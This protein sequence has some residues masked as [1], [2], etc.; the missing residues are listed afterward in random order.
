MGTGSTRERIS[1]NLAAIRIAKTIDAE[2]RLATPDEQQVLVRYVGWG[3]LSRIFEPWKYDEGKKD[4]D[5][6]VD[7]NKTLVDLLTTDEFSRARNSTQNAHYTSPVVIRAI[8][9]AVV[10]LGVTSGSVLEPSAGIG[11]FAGL[12]PSQL[13]KMSWAMVEKDPV[14][15]LI[16]KALYPGAFIQP[17]GFEAAALPAD[18]FTLAISNVPFGS[19]PITDPSFAGPSFMLQRIHNYFFGK[20]LDA[21]APGGLIA[22]ITTHGTLDSRGN[23]RVREYLASRADLVGAMRLPSTAFKANAGTDV[24]TDILFLRRRRAGESAHHA[25]PWLHTT[26]V[27]LPNKEGTPVEQYVN[28]YMLAHPEMVLGT[29]TSTGKMRAADAYN[30][31]PSGDLAE[32]LAAA[33][34]TLPAHVVDTSPPATTLAA[35]QQTQPPAGTRPFEYLLHEGRLAQIID[36]QVTPL[37]LRTK[38]DVARITKLL[39]VRAA[40]R[41]LYDLLMTPDSA[42]A[43][44]ARA[45]K[46]LGKAY[47]AFVKAHGFIAS[48]KNYRAFD[49]DPDMPLLL[50]LEDY[51]DERGVATKTAIFTQRT[52]QAERLARRANSPEHA[53]QLTLGE[54]GQIDLDRIGDLLDKSAADAARALQSAGL[55]LDTPSGWDLPA[56]YLAGNIRVR[57]REAEAAAELD[58]RYDGAVEALKAVM[59]ETIPSHKINVRLGASW[60]PVPTV[61]EFLKHATS[62]SLDSWT[63]TYSPFDGKWSIDGPPTAYA[64]SFTTPDVD[65]KTMLL[66]ALNDKRLTI[67]NK[68]STPDGGER[69]VVNKANTALARAK[70]DEIH[71][72]FGEWLFNSDP[73][74]RAWAVTAY[75]ERFNAYVQPTINGSYLTFPGMSAY[76]RERMRPHQRDAVGRVLSMG[77]LLFAHVVGAGKTLAMVAAGME[78][79]RLGLAR[80]PLYVVPNHL[81]AQW[82]SEFLQYYPNARLLVAK[83]EDLKKEN[84]KRF[85]A[86]IASGDWDAVVMPFSSF[87]LVSISPDAE[88]QYQRETLD[89][90]ETAIVQAWST[91]AQQPSRR[92]GKQKTPPSVKNLEKMRDRIQSKLD[93]LAQRPKDEMLWFEQLGVDALLVDEA[94]AFKNLYFQTRQQ[95]AGIP[96]DNDADRATDMYLKVRHINRLTNYRNVVLATG[97][98]VSN[99]MAEIFVLQKMLQEQTLDR[100]GVNQF[101]AWLAQFGTITVKPEQDPSGTGLSARARLSDFRN[102]PDLAAMVRQVVDVKMI[103]DLPELKAARPKLRGDKVE[104]PVVPITAR[105]L[106]YLAD[107][108]HRADN[109]DPRDKVTDNMGKLSMDGRLS[110]LDMR[111]I[112]RRIS[113][114]PGSKINRVVQDVYDIWAEWNDRKGVQLL[115]LDSGVPGTEENAAR[116][117]DVKDP[118]TGE[119]VGKRPPTEAEANRGLDLYKDM[120]TKL[121]DRGVPA[122]QIVFITDL[123]QVAEKKRDA[124]RKALFRRVRNGDIRILIGSRARM[125]TGMNVQDR[126]VALHNIDPAWKPSDIEQAN[127]RILRQGNLFLKEDPKFRVRILNHVT[128]GVG[129]AFGY[130]AYMWGLNEKKAE[131]IAKFW[132]GNLSERDLSLD[133]EQTVLTASEMKAIATGNPLIMEEG[134]L[135]ADVDRLDL[136]RQG[137]QESQREAAWSIEAERTAL[138]NLQDDERRYQ[139]MQAAITPRA[140]SAPLTAEVDGHTLEGHKVIGEAIL[141]AARAATTES[142]S[143]P[144]VWERWKRPQILGRFRGL[145]MRVEG[146]STTEPYIVLRHPKDEPPRYGEA[147]DSPYKRITVKLLVTDPEGPG[148]LSWREPTSL[149]RVIENQVDAIVEHKGSPAITM[150]EQRIAQFERTMSAPFAQQREYQQAVAKLEEVRKALGIDMKGEEIDAGDGGDEEPDGTEQAMEIEPSQQEP[151]SRRVKRTGLSPQDVEFERDEDVQQA[152]IEG[153]TATLPSLRGAFD[154]VSQAKSGVMALWA[155][156]TLPAGARAATVLRPEM[157]QLRHKTIVAAKA[158]RQLE[159]AFDRLTE[160]EWTAFAV[161]VDEGHVATLPAWQ[162]E[163][164]RLMKTINDQKLKTINSLGGRVPYTLNYYAREWVRPNAARKFIAGQLFR[165]RPLQGPAKFKK[166]RARHEDTGETFTFKELYDAG[167]R[168]VEGNPIRAHLRKWLEKDKWIMAKRTL[169]EL[170]RQGLAEYVPTGKSLKRSGWIPYDDGFGTVWGPPVAGISEAYDAGLMEAIHTFAQDQGIT[171]VRKMEMGK[172]NLQ[173][174][175]TWGY[176]VKGKDAIHSRFG[177]PEGVLMHEIGHVL[178]NKYGLGKA[179]GLVMN[180]ERAEEIN[181]SETP[182]KVV[183]ELRN[184]ADL[185]TDKTSSAGFRQ[186]VRKR[187]EVIANLVHAFLYVPDKAKEVAPSAYWAL[188]NMAKDTPS[189]AGLLEI[190]KA[191]SLRFASNT[192]AVDLGGP[193]LKGRYYGPRDAVRILNNHLSPGLRGNQA[194]DLYRRVGNVLNQVQLGLSGF[195][196]VGTSLNSVISKQAIAI[197]LASRG[198]ILE[199]AKRQLEV[200]IAPL[201]DVIRAHTIV[202]GAY[203]Q[204][205]NWRSLTTDMDKIIGAGGGVNWDTFWHN[206][207]PERFM[208]AMRATVAEAKAGHAVKASAHAGQTLLRLLPAIIE[209]QAKPIMQW[210]VPRLKVA[211]FMDLARME[212]ADLGPIPEPHETARVLG[213]AWD[214]VDNRFGELIYDNLFWNRIFKDVSMSLVRSMGWNLGTVREVLGAVPGQ[215]LHTWRQVAGGAGGGEPPTRLRNTGVTEGPDGEKVPVYERGPEPAITHKFAYFLSLLFWAA[216]FGALYQKLM[217]SLNPGEQEDGSTDTQTLLLDLYFP[218]TGG[219]TSDGR[220]ERASLPTYM[221]DVYAFW[222]HPITTMQHKVH[223]ILGLAGEV[224]WWNEDYFGNEIRDRSGPVEEQIRDVFDHLAKAYRPISVSSYFE[225]QKNRSGGAIAGVQSFLGINVAPASVTRTAMEEYIHDTRPPL[226]RTKSEAAKADLRREIRDLVSKGDLDEARRVAAEAGLST[227]Q[228]KSLVHTTRQGYVQRAFMGLGLRQALHAYEIGTPQER[229]QVIGILRAKSVRDL[230]GLQVDERARLR[231]AYVDALKLDRS[232]PAAASPP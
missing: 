199:A 34:K 135:A 35:F 218:R 64:S 185:R 3:G 204:D 201:V 143:S 112:D 231:D 32:Q 18:H 129:Q 6:W 189:L 11:H 165:R 10:R 228:L 69:T 128:S 20:A 173:G 172:P 31:E 57:L 216:I 125:G 29:P 210:W 63:V 157:A 38:D 141:D 198:H 166:Q 78:M 89:A 138:T 30:V 196:F 160:D 163:V 195:H 110:A 79:R 124:A 153:E 108:K 118:E 170:K 167:F 180:G 27:D 102:L 162:Q 116:L 119:K 142:V 174:H 46:A 200:P 148:G 49:E 215:A 171:M 7:A 45:Q 33:I 207:A 151:G 193:V 191:R 155:P 104:V 50:S 106:A 169:L 28:E 86:R 21:V 227:T 115:F 107:M 213:K 209:Q 156:D 190:Q 134:K 83:P 82:P 139:T 25:G 42:D 96:T 114:D 75:N 137:W 9:D 105:Q 85:T 203:A 87:V 224:L 61:T 62:S 97:T 188:Y 71:K 53:L 2:Q 43:D 161:A 154:E 149:T 74:R 14:T 187:S 72:A 13:V 159:R 145:T 152:L 59:P 94:H 111:L 225:R 220:P 84:R 132:S 113:D 60:I 48:E 219:V 41:A 51:D 70:K 230:P 80:K 150:R 214:S 127:G 223:P 52:I 16:A 206:S 176:V 130:D 91:D 36:G 192:V 177:G 58:A 186:Y 12:V 183:Q 182:S 88:M 147:T 144:G 205:P 126:L 229:G 81:I 19:I 26:A 181:F 226:H 39:P 232:A 47:D 184:L 117:R 40:L 221:K 194:Y 67:K 54:R 4:N 100:A 1:R 222:K 133:L 158:M 24:V 44:V 146:N 131:Q 22:F 23:Q 68:V 56:R 8:W 140:E 90:V 73:D 136:V 208:Q 121:V 55:I 120:K 93:K 5:L 66:A 103:D 179:I 122:N 98:P 164:A 65:T 212:M 92:G 15:A 76:W 37:T 123:D 211:A 202:K 168:P 217:T 197:E 99:S 101:D 77:N 178:D 175:K 109:M 95:A 17:V